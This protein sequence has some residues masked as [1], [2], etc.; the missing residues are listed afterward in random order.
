MPIP[1]WGLNFLC[2]H[3]FKSY[4]K[5]PIDFRISQVCTRSFFREGEKIGRIRQALRQHMGG[6]HNCKPKV[7]EHADPP[8]T[9]VVEPEVQ[10]LP[11][12]ESPTL[13]QQQDCLLFQPVV[14]TPNSNRLAE[15]DIATNEELGRF[16]S[17]QSTVEEIKALQEC[18]TLPHN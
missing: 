18:L 1:K 12:A 15:L 6:K 16:L 8:V 10:D 9:E 2:D 17:H 3:W 7:V 11:Q 14:T 4:E 13:A 5:P